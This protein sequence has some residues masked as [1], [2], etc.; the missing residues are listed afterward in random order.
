MA[1]VRQLEAKLEALTAGKIAASTP[2]KPGLV[3]L[4]G[5]A[6]RDLA[7]SKKF[8][9]AAATA[10]VLTAK[11]FGLNISQDAANQVIALGIGLILSIGAADFG[12]VAAATRDRIEK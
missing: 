5:K 4:V 12:K 10:V 3:M 7:G 2:G 6:L 11:H 9:V 8:L 1:N